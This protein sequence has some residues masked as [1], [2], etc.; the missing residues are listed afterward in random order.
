M[1]L[2]NQVWMNQ[3]W[4]NKIRDL[5]LGAVL[6]AL[7]MAAGCAPPGGLQHD[8]DADST[9]PEPHHVPFHAGDQSTSANPRPDASEALDN[10]LRP[11]TGLPFRDPESLPSGTLLTVRLKEGISADNP[12]ASA[13]FEAVVDDSVVID[14]NT[15]VARGATV[16]GRVESA[17]ASNV[18]RHRGYVRLTLDSID[19]AG[20]DLPVQTSSL[21]ARGNARE[22]PDS[23]SDGSPNVIHLEKGRL[24]TFRLTEPV[25][26]ASQR[27]ISSH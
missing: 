17:R 18:K 15:L 23:V 8:A 3:V 4:M 12:D 20:R 26:L 16:A 19:I 22:T 24:L 7:V 13:T 21:F 14:G 6:L 5:A 10:G 1:I 2:M 25:Y 9:Q 11:A 27:S